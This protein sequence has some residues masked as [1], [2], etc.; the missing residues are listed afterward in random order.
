MRSPEA[1]LECS[2]YH[3]APPQP[4]AAFPS[5]GR[6]VEQAA[7]VATAI[8]ERLSFFKTGCP[9]T[10][11]LTPCGRRGLKSVQ[12]WRKSAVHDHGILLSEIFVMS[13][14]MIRKGVKRRLIK[15]AQLNQVKLEH[16]LREGV[17]TWCDH[18][19][20]ENNFARTP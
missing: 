11:E 14:Q 12:K 20:S 16:F 15:K 13:R 1:V 2:A 5:I 4:F 3:E 10:I 9:S 8:I 6:M 17:L 18:K 19:N 7:I